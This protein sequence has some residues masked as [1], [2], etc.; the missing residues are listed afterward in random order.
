MLE[1]AGAKNREREIDGVVENLEDMWRFDVSRRL[2]E[3]LS[4]HGRLKA[5]WHDSLAYSAARLGD[6]EAAAKHI[7]AALQ[8]QPRDKNFWSNKGLFLLMQGQLTEAGMALSKARKLA[9]KDPIILGNLE[10]HEYLTEHGG[11][12]FDYLVRPLDREKMDELAN[13]EEWE[14]VDALRTEFNGCRMEAFAQSMF[15]K[16]GQSRSC[17]ASLIRTLDSFF[18][19]VERVDAGGM[20]VHEDIDLVRDNFKAI[21]HK[22]IYKFGDVDRETIDDVFEGLKAYYGFL[23]EKNVVPAADFRQLEKAIG[24]HGQALIAKMERYNAI[25]HDPAVSEKRKEKIRE[26]LFEGDHAWPHL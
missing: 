19:F 16:G 21:M 9:P 24:R 18:D 12:Y 1:L 26:E 25:R 10:A 7:E 22:F 13:E 5:D 8:L 15:M 17:L 14:D 4:E 3:V 6:F 20:F 2:M 11:N 23:A